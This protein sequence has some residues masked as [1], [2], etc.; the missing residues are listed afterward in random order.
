M[1]DAADCFEML[2][3]IQDNIRHHISGDGGVHKYRLVNVKY[4]RCMKCGFEHAKTSEKLSKEMD[5]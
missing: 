5:I 2:V 3:N 4:H 1:M